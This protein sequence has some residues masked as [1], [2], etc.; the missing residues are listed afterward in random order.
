MQAPPLPVPPPTPGWHP[1]WRFRA[2]SQQ[3]EAKGTQSVLFVAAARTLHRPR[4]APLSHRRCD[5]PRPARLGVL[6]AAGPDW[7]TGRNDR[8]K[9]K[10][11]CWAS[12]PVWIPKYSPGWGGIY[13]LAPPL[14]S[15][16]T[17]GQSLNLSVLLFPHL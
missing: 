3:A 9:P 2:A 10:T 1:A 11:A 7:L 17:L 12:W 13:V 5:L 16:V 8:T 14:C 15:C 4:P 6:R